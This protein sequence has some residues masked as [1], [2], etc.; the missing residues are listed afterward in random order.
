VA[1]RTKAAIFAT[2]DRDRCAR[3][4]GLHT[5]PAH[6]CLCRRPCKHLDCSGAYV[7]KLDAEGILHREGD[8]YPLN[9]NRIAYVHFLRRERKASPRSE[10]ETWF[11][12]QQAKL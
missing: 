2:D 5:A 6:R 7:Q 4:Q 12:Q 3:P 11:Q 9:R 10:A 1:G 8:A